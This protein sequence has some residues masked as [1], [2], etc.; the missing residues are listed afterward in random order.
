[1]AERLEALGK[2]VRLLVIPG[3]VHIFNFREAGEAGV[4]WSATLQ[5]FDQYLLP[6]ALPSP[7][8]AQAIVPG[9]GAGPGR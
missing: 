7:V 2:P 6:V 1:M 9:A 4:A 8:P 3:G 5:W